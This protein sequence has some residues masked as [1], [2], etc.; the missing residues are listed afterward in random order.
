MDPREL[1]ALIERFTCSDGCD[2]LTMKELKALFSELHDV[3]EGLIDEAD[4]ANIDKINKYGVLADAVEA[5]IEKVKAEFAAKLGEPEPVAA[6]DDDEGDNIGDFVA[7]RPDANADTDDDGKV[8]GK[9]MVATVT[10]RDADGN[11]RIEFAGEIKTSI[12]LSEALA[13][14]VHRYPNLEAGRRVPVVQGTYSN[15]NFPVIER[16]DDEFTA[17]VKMMEAVELHG[18][19]NEEWLAADGSFCAPVTPDYNFCDL[20]DGVFDLFQASLPVV[21]PIRGRVQYMVTPTNDQF[22]DQ[23]GGIED[24]TTVEGVGTLFTEADSI[25]VDAADDATWKQ[26]IEVDCPDQGPVAELEAHYTCVEWKHFTWKAYPEYIDLY[27]RKSLQAHL[28]KESHHLLQTVQGLAESPA[29]NIEAFPG[30]VSGFFSAIDVHVTAYRDAFWLRREQVLDVVFPRWVLNMLRA[31]L[32]RRADADEIAALRATDQLITSLFGELNLRVN[33]V[34]GWQRVGQHTNG[35][36][37]PV[38]PVI[39]LTNTNTWPSTFDMLVWVPGSVVL[40][41]DASWNIGIER[42]RDTTLQRQNKYSLFAE[43]FYGIGQPCPYPVQE[44]TVE[45]CPTGASS[46]R[47]TLNCSDLTAVVNAPSS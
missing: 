34:T 10:R 37:T 3:R 2:G 13:D 36:G 6:D 44:L 11:D 33:F 42:L 5:K 7:P 39:P 9:V 25:A 23:W 31:A 15:D 46:A 45:F 30:S 18:K 40:L 35:A 4:E 14:A 24:N 47:E 32:A 29:Y 38:S 16:G 21:R 1:L 43:T 22:Y 28:L 8:T 27:T 17:T 19:R 41:Q 26:C 12:E 20:S